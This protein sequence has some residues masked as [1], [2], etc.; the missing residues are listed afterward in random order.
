M[1]PYIVLFGS[2]I[3]QGLGISS[4][5]MLVNYVHESDN[6]VQCYLNDI[7]SRMATVDRNKV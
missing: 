3:D 2:T 5:V 4:F 7:L 1:V 6:W